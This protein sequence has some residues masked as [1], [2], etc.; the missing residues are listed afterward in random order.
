[1]DT[2]VIGSIIEQETAAGEEYGEEV[3]C[4]GWNPQLTQ[5]TE[6]PEAKLNRHVDL[7]ADLV[8]VD[9]DTFLKRMYKY[10]C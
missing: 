4:A 3:L 10:Q 7:P 1:M 5:A 2:I 8:N 9:V 6:L